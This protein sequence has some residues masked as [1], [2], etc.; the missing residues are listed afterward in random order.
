MEPLVIAFQQPLPTNFE[1][2]FSVIVID[3]LMTIATFNLCLSIF[4][5]AMTNFWLS[6]FNNNR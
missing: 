2:H 5:I 1:Q 4:G 3:Q 6:L